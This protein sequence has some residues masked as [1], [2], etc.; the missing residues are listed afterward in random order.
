MRS[1]RALHLGD[2]ASKHTLPH[3]NMAFVCINPDAK[4]CSQCGER[5][6]LFRNQEHGYVGSRCP[7]CELTD[8]RNLLAGNFGRESCEQF[9]T[10]MRVSAWVKFMACAR[11]DY[12]ARIQ[13]EDR[14]FLR[15]CGIAP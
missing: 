15:Q 12:L 7:N 5:R 13:N 2:L 9:L 1:C 10:N 6:R 3:S 4:I 11:A 8:I 14:E